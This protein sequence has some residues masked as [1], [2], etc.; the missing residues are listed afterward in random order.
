MFG[1]RVFRPSID[2]SITPW[3]LSN[4]F[5]FSTPN[6]ISFAKIPVRSA[7]SFLIKISVQTPSSSS[8]SAFSDSSTKGISATCS[9]CSDR[10]TPRSK[11]FYSDASNL[12]G[13]AP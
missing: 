1:G 10:L 3:P 12:I 4:C 8:I 13:F 7:S 9:A 6:L 2:R 11:I 5:R